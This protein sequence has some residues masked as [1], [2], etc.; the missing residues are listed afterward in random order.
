M[1]TT[2]AEETQ[3]G[4]FYRPTRDTIGGVYYTRP[5]T[6]KRTNPK[7]LVARL[8]ERG[9]PLAAFWRAMLRL[10]PDAVLLKQHQRGRCVLNTTPEDKPTK[11]NRWE[12]TRVVLMPP[13]QKLRIVRRPPGYGGRS[14]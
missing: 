3:P 13:G 2:T 12:I 8:E 10:H 14:E 6:T 7:A 9:D 5:K 4:S 11:S 1:A